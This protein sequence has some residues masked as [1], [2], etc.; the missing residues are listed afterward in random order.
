MEHRK[1]LN[2]LEMK[3][4]EF[5]DKIPSDFLQS[6]CHSASTVLYKGG[7]YRPKKKNAF[8]VYNEI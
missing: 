4:G 2:C 3:V 1:S 5:K 6:H 7:K 8:F